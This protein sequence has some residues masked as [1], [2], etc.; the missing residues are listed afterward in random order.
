MKL[1]LATL[2]VMFLISCN[3]QNDLQEESNALN[4]NNYNVPELEGVSNKI[5]PFS[6][7]CKIYFEELFIEAGVWEP[8][9]RIIEFVS[10]EPKEVIDST[11]FN[12]AEQDGIYIYTIKEFIE[13][14]DTTLWS[15]SG[16]YSNEKQV[17]IP[18]HIEE[19]KIIFDTI[20]MVHLP[21]RNIEID[22]FKMNLDTIVDQGKG[23]YG[24]WKRIDD[25]GEFFE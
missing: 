23:Y 12:Y 16:F 8:T 1:I 22:C 5:I 11:G 20:M 7:E 14:N 21:F 10:F 24:I 9:A 18:L 2:L 17:L 4:S 15:Q 19:K 25:D 13:N 3:R 6:T